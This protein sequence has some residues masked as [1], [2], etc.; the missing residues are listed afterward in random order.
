MEK[1]MLTAREV[2]AYLN[3]NEKMVYRLVREAPIRQ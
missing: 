2:A 1:E 3:I